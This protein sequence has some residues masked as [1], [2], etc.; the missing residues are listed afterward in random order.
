MKP[1]NKTGSRTAGKCQADAQEFIMRTFLRYCIDEIEFSP[2]FIC[3]LVVSIAYLVVTTYLYVASAHSAPSTAA[4]IFIAVVVLAAQATK[5]ALMFSLVRRGGD[6]GLKQSHTLVT[7]GI[8]RFSRNPAYL[9]TILQNVAWSL[10]LMAA[11][12]GQPAGVMAVTVIVALPLA[13]F[14]VLDRLVIRQEEADLARW[15]PASYAG[16]AGGVNRW[17]GRRRRGAQA[18]FST[19]SSQ[20]S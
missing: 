19:A 4:V 1:A 2:S 7:D 15:H 11:I 13:H 3:D 12:V 18:G 16:Y 17:I 8:Y 10:L 20:G 14:L 5:V 9:V 6:A